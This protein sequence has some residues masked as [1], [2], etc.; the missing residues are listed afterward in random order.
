[1]SSQVTTTRLLTS[2]NPWIQLN[3]IQFEQAEELGRGTFGVV[4]RATYQGRPVAVKSLVHKEDKD[5]NG[6]EAAELLLGEANKMMSLDHPRIVKFMGFNLETCSLVLEY[7]PK[8]GLDVYIAKH[9]HM[10]WSDRITI[11]S[12][13]AEAMAYLHSKQRLDGRKKPEIFHQDLKSA[14]VLLCYEQGQL[15]GKISDFGLSG[16]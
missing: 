5:F 12:D 15:R 8:G 3:E 14:N 11:A 4:K 1:M 2:C 10:L 7:M 16:K 9:P 13:M 6:L